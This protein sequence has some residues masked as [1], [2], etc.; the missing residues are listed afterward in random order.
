[1]RE[2]AFC[3]P[4]APRRGTYRLATFLPD[5]GAVPGTHRVA[6]TSPQGVI[7][8]AV[9]QRYNDPS[10]SGLTEEVR[11]ELNEIDLKLTTEGDCQ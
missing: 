9:P 3:S 11:P 5:D 7:L 8:G 2:S 10:T 1:M 4:D 6:V